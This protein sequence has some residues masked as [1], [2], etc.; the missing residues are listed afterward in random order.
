MKRIIS[1][2]VYVEDTGTEKGRGVFAKRNFTQDELIEA[3]PV[4]VLF[5]PFQELPLRIRRIVYNWQNL[6][7]GENYSSGLI[8]GYGSMYNHN[9]PANMRY[10]ANAE[11]EVMY[12]Y[13]ARDIQKDEELTVNYNDTQGAPDSEEDNWFKKQ[14][15]KP[16][17]NQ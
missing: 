7:H 13:A 12:Y 1:P 9:N 3:A 8:Y 4:L 10:E 15:I 16:I 17:I 14:N 2:D 5:K 11:D 6:T